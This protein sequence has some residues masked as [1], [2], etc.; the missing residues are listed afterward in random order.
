MYLYILRHAEAHDIGY[1][2]IDKDTER[3][4]TEYGERQAKKT[5]K[6]LRKLDVKLDGILSSP[7]VRA[8]QTAQS[9]AEKMEFKGKIQTVTALQP[10]MDKESLRK[11]LAKFEVES[12]VLI[13]G[14][15]PDL[16]EYIQY[17]ISGAK[18]KG[19]SL[20]KAG[21]ACLKINGPLAEPEKISF[22]WL[23]NYPLVETIAEG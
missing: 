3:P 10:G 4:L 6:A 7:L 1:R 13:V 22:L 20:D 9:L 15:Q 21:I 17:L 18:G 16:G 19:L 11:E 23:L 2:G 8:L 14:H 5:G 12:H